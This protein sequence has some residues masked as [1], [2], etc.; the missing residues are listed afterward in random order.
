MAHHFII[1]PTNP[2]N[3]KGNEARWLII[4][5][6]ITPKIKKAD[7]AISLWK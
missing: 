6:L 1:S 7:L 3:Q 2:D 4:N 5:E